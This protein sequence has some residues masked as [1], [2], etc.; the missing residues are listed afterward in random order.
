M[1][2]TTRKIASQEGGFLNFI[3][4][5]ITAGLLLLNNVLT[6]LGKS[7]QMH[8][9]K[10]KINLLDRIRQHYYFQIKA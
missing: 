3:G 5:L 9:V 1:K 8:R 10:R 7:T 2:E 6:P 4:K